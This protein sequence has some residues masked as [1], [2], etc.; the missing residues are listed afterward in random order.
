LDAALALHAYPVTAATAAFLRQRHQLLIDGRWVG[1]HE[2][3]TIEVI[4]PATARRIA[5]VSAATAPDVDAAVA[6]ARAAV[7]R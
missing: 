6:A 1:P 5:T 4:D 3:G 2:G 7:D